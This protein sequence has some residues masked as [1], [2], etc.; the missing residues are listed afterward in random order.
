MKGA[1][2]SSAELFSETALLLNKNFKRVAPAHL[3]NGFLSASVGASLLS[4]KV[5]RLICD[6]AQEEREGGLSPS[7]GL[8]ASLHVAL[9]PDRRAWSELGSLVPLGAPLI[10]RGPSDDGLGG[11]VWA[12]LSQRDPS[13][14]E[15]LA[16]LMRLP[17][18]P[19][20]PLDA[21]TVELLG[22][23]AT[24]REQGAPP[25]GLTLKLTL[26]SASAGEALL[27]SLVR[28]THVALSGGDRGRS[29]ADRVKALTATVSLAAWFM[30]VRRPLL[31]GSARYV[32]WGE[33][34]PMFFYAGLPPGDLSSSAVKLSAASFEALCVHYERTLMSE[35]EGRPELVTSDEEPQYEA[36]FR[37]LYPV[38]RFASGFRVLGR[39]V[40]VAGPDRSGRPRFILETSALGLIIDATVARGE[41]LA[42]E[43]W[44][45]RAY[46]RLGL[47]LAF[48]RETD[49]S[50]LLRGLM[51][52]GVIYEALCE[53]H[54]A[55]R[56]RL[57]R[58]GLATE[59]SDG[60]LEVHQREGAL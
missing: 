54:A 43:D 44:V 39:Q 30:I 19:D 11:E 51:P 13:L 33:L 17:E 59:Y 31:L 8:R 40:G 50:G 21:L 6:T 7:E 34:P 57:L 60:E 29:R 1:Q 32:R 49:V 28:A 24:E 20:D 42:F 3:I 58:A 14:R 36:V 22:L 37:A 5:R 35:L 55:L 52:E 47:L 15:A 53:N 45:D 18:R 23:L 38:G 46:E 48:G 16:E 10:N 56:R 9:N 26:S 4:N 12:L 25:E 27:D 41:R 2:I